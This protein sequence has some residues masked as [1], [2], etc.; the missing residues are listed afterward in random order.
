MRNLLQDAVLVCRHARGGEGRAESMCL[1]L[2][3]L[4]QYARKSGKSVKHEP[5]RAINVASW[6]HLMVGL[7]DDRLTFPVIASA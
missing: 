6:C 4:H 7:V 1:R 3:L 5:E 2:V